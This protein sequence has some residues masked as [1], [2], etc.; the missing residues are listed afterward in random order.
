M[1]GR[2]ERPWDAIV[3]G[4]G[5]GG[6]M[7]AQVLVEAGCRVL[8]IER[9]DWV[10]RGPANWEPGSVGL[11][12]PYY[13]AGSPY[14]QVGRR[15]SEPVGAFHCV[16]GPSV[17][18]GGVALR[19]READF[20]PDPGIV[21][22]SGARWPFPYA[23]LEPCYSRAE[24]LL[25]VAG[26]AGID[27]TDPP[28]SRPYS[29]APA[30]FAAVTRRIAAAAE[31]LDLHPF[32]LPLAINH[33][34][35]SGRSPC[36]ACRT[37]DGFA[38]AVEAKNDVATMLI[39]PLMARGLELH[40]NTVAT[41]LEHDGERITS[42]IAVD[43]LH[44]CVTRYR[45]DRVFLAAGALA[46]PHLVLASRLTCLNPGGHVIGRFLMR[47]LNDVVLGVFPGEPDREH[48]FHK[49]LGIH[50]FYFGD[51]SLDRPRG[52]LGAIQQLA[53]PPASLVRA[54]LPRGLSALAGLVNHLTGLL[55]IT[56][57]RPDYANRVY[58]GSASDE[59][60]LPQL[61][62]DH[63]YGSRDRA[64]GRALRT[65]ARAILRRAGAWAT[66][67]HRVGTFSHAVGTMRIGCDPELSALDPN[68]RF[69]GLDNLFVVDGSALATSGGVNPSL[70]IAAM[71]LRT[72][73][74]ALN[75]AI[76]QSG[77]LDH[78]IA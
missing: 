8:M 1:I 58:L 22:G 26:R 73:S 23:E 12:G 72:A 75:L 49:Q 74:R 43:R 10:A 7:A 62:I 48:R 57:D 64:A 14:R 68:G 18:Y 54:N 65:R 56:E 19:F 61:L 34:A 2:A 45:A 66:Y 40:T 52:K 59:Y 29:A 5:F 38:C 16:G 11:L 27:P 37:C 63:R 25:G 71:A 4:S 20:D 36:Q 50:D 15:A 41:R 78:A 77:G 67:S 33:R 44:G 32:P 39:R 76:P 53:T 42:V 60:G 9:G 51:P 30:P 3:I 31:S 24:Q 69:R 13:S 47:H 70:T 6:G 55:T 28:R 21:A 35:Q 17:F 46:S